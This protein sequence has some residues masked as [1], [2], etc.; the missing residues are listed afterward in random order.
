MNWAHVHLILNHFPVVTGI[1]GLPLYLAAM[2]RRSDGLRRVAFGVFIAAAALALPAYFTG[3][4]AE[5]RVGHLPGVSE[6]DID[7]HEE[8]AEIATIVVGAQG[9]LALGALVLL[10]RRPGLP[11]PIAVTLLV[12]SIAGAVLMARTANLGGMIRH[13][14]IR[15]GASTSAAPGR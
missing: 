13:G 8:S 12:L 9:V 3:E 10:K 7:R 14:E 4:P 6:N 11:G 1:L 5:E 15:S 2:L